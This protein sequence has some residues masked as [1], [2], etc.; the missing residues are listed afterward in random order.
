MLD[1]PD[2]LRDALPDEVL[3]DAALDGGDDVVLEAIEHSHHLVA[4]INAFAQPLQHHQARFAEFWGLCNG[5]FDGLNPGFLFIFHGISFFNI[6]I[7]FPL[8]IG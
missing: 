5:L 7:A 4:G 8:V 2:H 6:S 3:K 1:S